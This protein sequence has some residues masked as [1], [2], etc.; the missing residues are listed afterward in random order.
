MYMI[1]APFITYNTIRTI[2]YVRKYSSL[3]YVQCYM[4]TNTA[5]CIFYYA[6]CK[7]NNHTAPCFIF[8]FVFSINYNVPCFILNAICTQIQL[9]K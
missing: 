1:T 3:Y 9:A 6:I 4:Y 5:P 8:D 7:K 2:L